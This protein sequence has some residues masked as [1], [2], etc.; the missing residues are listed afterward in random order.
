M[1]GVSELFTEFKSKKKL[2]WEG[3]PGGGEIDGG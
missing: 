2:F 3:G 1:A